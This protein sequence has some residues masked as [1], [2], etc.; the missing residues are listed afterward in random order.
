MSDIKIEY[1]RL[2]NEIEKHDK[3]YYEDADPIISDREYDRLYQRLIE[4]EN[5]HPEF[6]DPNSPSQRVGG[7]PIDAF[8]TIEHSIPM[9]SL[10]NT[11]NRQ[12]VDDFHNRVVKL[13]GHD[14]VEYIVEL[15]YD[16]VALSLIFE[17]NKLIRAVTRGDGYKGDDVTHN[18]K[19]IKSIPLKTYHNQI[20][21][22]EVR[23]EVY[24]TNSQFEKI[25]QERRINNDKLYANPR[26]TTAGSLKLLDSSITT[27]RNLQIACYHLITDDINIQ[28]NSQ[29][30]ELLN[31][32]NLPVSHNYKV[33]KSVDEVFEYINYWEKERTSLPFMIDGIVIKVNKKS[34]Q[35]ELGYIAKAPRWAIAYKYEA[36][37]KETQLLDIQFQIGRT[38]AVTPVAILKP[39]F[40]SGTTVSR[41]SIHNADFIYEKDIR[42][43]DTVEIEKGGEIIPKVLRVNLEK[44]PEDTE[45]FVFP[46]TIEGMKVRRKDGEAAHYVDDLKS[47]IIIKRKIE[48]F[49]SR[50][51][52]DITGLGEQIINKFVDLGFLKNIS[53]IYNLEN[54]A[55][56][57]SKLEGFGGKSTENL[58]QSIEDSKNRDLDRLIF[59]LGIRFIGSG[60]AKI[61]AKSFNNLDNL[62]K[63]SYEELIIIDEIGEKMAASIV[64]FFKDEDNIQLIQKLREKGLNFEYKQKN[65]QGSSKLEGKTFVF[66]GELENYTRDEAAKLIEIHGGK[67]VKSVSKKTSYLVLGAN[68]GSKY[69]KALALGVDILNENLFNELLHSLE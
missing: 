33:C 35:E 24:M 37:T 66:T 22:Y 67:E 49:A 15:K 18:A 7:K 54:Q 56:D 39:V 20:H 5:T 38:G 2:L 23:G 41:A 51:A 42:I 21:N 53:D 10:T 65:K 52:M 59:S 17:E 57:L 27:K 28:Y 68:P 26:N 31:E 43:G 25:N 13:L 11:Y 60:G 58:I 4:I 3:A 50:K 12:E 36:E 6:K 48:H 40:L 19:T 44:R 16:G 55:E 63:S 61:L 34:Q 8:A 45:K 47:D 30:M 14:E 9:L 69:D 1:Q 29:A 64:D 46:D 62:A 32:L